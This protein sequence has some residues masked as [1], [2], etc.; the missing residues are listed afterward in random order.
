MKKR[1][2]ISIFL[3]LILFSSYLTYGK[4]LPSTAKEDM[5]INKL[6]KQIILLQDK[7]KQLEEIKHKKIQSNIKDIKIGLALSGG[8]AKGLAHIGVLKALE[9]LHIKPDYI[10]GTSMGAVV[11]ALY[12]IGYTPDQI[13]AILS[14]NDWDSFVNGTFMQ[15]KIPLEKKVVDKKYMLSIRYDNKFNFSLPKGFG[16][17]QMIYFELKKL[18]SNVEGITNFNDL[19][20]PLRVIATDLNSGKAVALDSGDLAKAITASIA[21]PTVFDPVE[22][23][24]KLYVDGL[25]TRNFPVIDAINMGADIVIGSDVGNEVKDKKDYN[26]IS[27]LNQLVTIQSSSS[28]KEQQELATILITPDILEYSATDLD[29][30]K[31]FIVLGEEATFEQEALLKDL[32][33][34]NYKPNKLPLK[35]KDIVIKNIEYT[36]KLSQKDKNIINSILDNAKNRDL[37][38]TQLEEYM[39]KVYGNDLIDS[40]YYQIIGDTLYV[41]ANM[42]PTNSIGVGVNYLTG[43]GTTFNVGTN[44]TNFGTIGNNS[45][46][47][48]KVG[49]YLG[50]TFKNF[51]YYGYSNKI[52]LFANL[53]YNE[54]PLFLYNG[55]KKISDSIVKNA[56]FETGVL[57][58]YNNKLILSYGIN[59]MYTKLRQKTGSLKDSSINYNKNY[60][61]AF[62]RMSYD[63]LEE[64]NNHPES[65][66]KGLFEYS[67][68]GS[69]NKSKSNF[70]GPTYMLDGFIP[71]N[72][73]F[74]FQYGFSGGVISGDHNSSKD[75]YLRI[76]GTKGNFKQREFAFYG[77]AFQQKL[78]DQFFIG[79]L[80][81]EYKIQPNLYLSGHWNIGTF[82]EVG[83]PSYPEKKE[84][85]QDYL[86]GVGIALT[87]ESLF[88]PIAFSISKNNDHGDFLSQISIGYV[89]E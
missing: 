1:Y 17:T 81:L 70:Y 37:T 50:V 7:I 82:N 39:M 54:N 85:W 76:G 61:G 71:I 40:V 45:L 16:N 42:N 22:I 31:E 53:S 35:S 21:I 68:E 2:T 41:D 33:C 36:H 28:T 12:S 8:G 6:K 4:T 63:T 78:V 89:L 80:G 14:Q 56:M 87:Y 11:G 3:I 55:N 46:L 51:I 58:Q 10:T 86:Q 73:K 83:I 34:P 49:D 57:T 69:F 25:I 15:S 23:D 48:L 32:S 20:I 62:V 30:G 77:L 47:N 18:L 29:K 60:N 38:P 5:E 65:G 43:Y 66:V 24:G 59:T 72:K 84:L 26:I 13:E 64:I 75:R 27:V 79:K 88:G 44:I 19:P 9:E 74:I 67:W 52:G